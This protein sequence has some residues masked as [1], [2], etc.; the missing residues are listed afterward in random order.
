MGL[1]EL[2]HALVH[3]REVRRRFN[4][5]PDHV[6]KREFQVTDPAA[7]G[8][9]YSMD[10]AKIA[11]E[12]G[13]QFTS[14]NYSFMDGEFAPCG[15]RHQE[16]PRGT[17]G[18]GFATA[19]YPAPTPKIFRIEPP[20]AKAAD[21]AFELCV[22]GQ[23]FSPDATIEVV[24]AAGGPSLAVGHG[25]VFGTFRCSEAY[26]VVSPAAGT[27]DVVVVNAPMSPHKTRISSPSGTNQLVIT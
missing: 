15:H 22:Y 10:P 17:G 24:P 25:R 27:F 1:L 18:G 19:Q 2:I 6:A 13:T 21:G 8:A 4:T 11:Q 26:G 5:N 9:L 14:F 20:T 3:D 7:L 23:S 12:I 16:R